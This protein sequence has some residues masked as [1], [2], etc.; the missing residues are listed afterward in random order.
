MTSLTTIFA[1][2]P[3]M[4]KGSMGADLQFPLSL[5]LIIGLS[6]GTLVSLFFVPML[7]YLV[8]NPRERRKS[9]RRN[10]A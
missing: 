7:Y 8:Y 9:L 5:A 4:T 6:V 3:F 2:L 1:M 10:P